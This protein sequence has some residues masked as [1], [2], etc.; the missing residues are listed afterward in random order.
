MAK[1]G[2]DPII[3]ATEVSPHCSASATLSCHELGEDDLKVVYNTLHPMAEKYMFFGIQINVKMSEIKK[4]Q[5]LNTNPNECLLEVLSIRLK[6]IPSLTWNDIHT[7]L[8]S[9]SIG[10]GKLAD[11]IKKEYG[12][13]FSPDPSSTQAALYK[14]SGSDVLEKGKRKR[15]SARRGKAYQHSTQ[16]SIEDLGEETSERSESKRYKKSSKGKKRC[17]TLKREGKIKGRLGKPFGHYTKQCFKHKITEKVVA[18]AKE[19]SDVSEANVDGVVKNIKKRVSQTGKQRRDENESSEVST[20]EEIDSDTERKS[21]SIDLSQNQQVKKSEAEGK[22]CS[23]KSSATKYEA[24]DSE[25]CHME[26]DVPKCSKRKRVRKTSDSPV[27][28]SMPPSCSTSPEEGRKKDDLRQRKRKNKLRRCPTRKKEIRGQ[29]SSS[30]S[31]EI[32]D[33]SPECDINFSETE[34]K[35]LRKVFK[36]FFGKLCCV[37]KDPIETAAELQAKHAISQSTM[38]K[39]FRSPESNQEKIIALVRALEKRINCR[40]DRIFTIINV[41][42]HN[43]LLE[44]A[45]REMWIETGKSLTTFSLSFQMLTSKTGVN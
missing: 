17:Y 4:I 8:M 2:D 1:K 3:M 10:E 23:S 15:K 42:Q 27:A 12:H 43:K 14:K 9:E 33:S 29:E 25:T 19:C 24:S 31:S 28:S 45:G 5:R 11:K 16:V 35:Q 38:E 18:R 40:P 34:T 6:Q 26:Q 36:C 32:D 21:I 22:M 13:L 44:N 41:F 7:A 39:L 37:I 30:S 20:K